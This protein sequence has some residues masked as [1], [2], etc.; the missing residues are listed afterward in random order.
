MSKEDVPFGQKILDSPFLLL[1]AGVVVMFGCF[2]MWGVVEV[3]MLPQAT[4][5]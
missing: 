4:L 2:T 5:P 1:V 3:M